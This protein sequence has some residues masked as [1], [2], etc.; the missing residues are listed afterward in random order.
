MKLRDIVVRDAIVADLEANQRDDVIRE[1]V[2]ALVSA[3]AAPD[4]SEDE[5]VERLLVR[6]RKGSTGFGRGVAVPHVK[7]PS[8]TKMAAGIGI[9]QG[10]VEFESL[11]R[12]PVYSV[13][14]L[15][16]PEDQPEEHLQAMESI[17]KN[18]S[19]DTFRRFLRQAGSVEDVWSLLEEA[20]TQQLGG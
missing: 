19:K 2:G 8:V 14:M 5:L 18:L 7:H 6:E 9:S 16:S 12:Q 13:V 11:D 1:M 20:D 10:G 3:G 4:G 17:F 15:L